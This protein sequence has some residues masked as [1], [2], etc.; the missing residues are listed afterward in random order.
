[1]PKKRKTWKQKITADL[2][3]KAYIPNP[4]TFS[5]QEVVS[6]QQ[7]AF[8]QSQNLDNKKQTVHAI[9]TSAYHYLSSD[10]LKTLILTWS[11]VL[12]ELVLRFVLKGV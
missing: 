8:Q 2:R 4:D 11:I 9:S 7:P 3:Q 1:M 12:V 6:S 10:L 5:S